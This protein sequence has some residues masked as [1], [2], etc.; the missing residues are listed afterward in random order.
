M[1][2]RELSEQV[3]EKEGEVRKKRTSRRGK[4]GIEMSRERVRKEAEGSKDKGPVEGLLSDNDLCSDTSSASDESEFR[5]FICS[6]MGNR[7]LY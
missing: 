6:Q 7:A 2:Q 4:K 5:A 1:V 3:G